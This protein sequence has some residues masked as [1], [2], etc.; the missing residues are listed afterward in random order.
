VGGRPARRKFDA[1][2]VERVDRAAR[3]VTQLVEPREH[4]RRGRVAFVS[5]TEDVETSTPAGEFIVL[6]MAT[7]GQVERA[8]IADRIRSGFHR[9]NVLGKSLGR[10]RA[11]IQRAQVRRLRAHGLSDRG[12]GHRLGVSAA[13]VHRVVRESSL[14]GP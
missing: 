1:V 11:H 10:P 8:R 7:I 2:I 4:L 13:L 5:I 3:S 14:E 6:I 9:A 12:I